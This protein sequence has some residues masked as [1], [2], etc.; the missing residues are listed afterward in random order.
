MIFQRTAITPL[1]SCL[2]K[3]DHFTF[4]GGLQTN[5]LKRSFGTIYKLTPPAQVG[6]AWTETTLFEFGGGATG[7]HPVGQLAISPS[8]TLFGVTEV[9]GANEDGVAFSLVP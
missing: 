9:G 5:H 3:T 8:G 7:G 2:A 6:G 1:T 4:F